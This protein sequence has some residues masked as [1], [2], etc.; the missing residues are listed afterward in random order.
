VI[1]HTRALFPKLY[2]SQI[3]VGFGSNDFRWLVAFSLRVLKVEDWEKFSADVEALNMQPQIV[4]IGGFGEQPHASIFVT[5][6]AFS[7]TY[8]CKI[9]E[10]MLYTSTWSLRSSNNSYQ[11]DTFYLSLF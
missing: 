10:N 5:G 4:L 1:K 7:Q 9:K 3:R 11:V 8:R 6:F 2:D